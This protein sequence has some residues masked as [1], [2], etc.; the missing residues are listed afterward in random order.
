M[1]QSWRKQCYLRTYCT[2]LYGSA[3]I[4]WQRDL[5][6]KALSVPKTP[7]ILYQWHP[8]LQSFKFSFIFWTL[9]QIH[10]HDYL[11]S[12][13]LH[14]VGHLCVTAPPSSQLL[15]PC[16]FIYSLKLS[17]TSSLQF[18]YVHPSMVF[19]HNRGMIWWNGC[20]QRVST[21]SPSERHKGVSYLLK[22]PNR[23][24][25]HGLLLTGHLYRLPN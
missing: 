17:V 12:C 11:P 22:L 5:E 1:K 10:Q 4:V 6:T 3:K 7:L 20:L 21:D 16:P 8:G 18:H 23:Q 24:F 14:S 13:G 9:P 2:P 19:P 15:P 25:H